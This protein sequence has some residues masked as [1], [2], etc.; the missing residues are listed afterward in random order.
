MEDDDN[1]SLFFQRVL[2]RI[3]FKGACRRVRTVDEAMEY[4][5]GAARFA[6]REVYPLPD[7]LVMDS[8]VRGTRTAVDMM[9]W[10]QGQDEFRSLTKVI[11]T[12]GMSLSA[13]RELMELG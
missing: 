4:L 2:P 3:G 1:D 12:G 11:L 13:Q 8:A 7:V 9:K 6:D 5:Q 10:I